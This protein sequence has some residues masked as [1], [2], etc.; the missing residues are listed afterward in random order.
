MIA[1]A[2]RENIGAPYRGRQEAKERGKGKGNRQ[3]DREQ[4]EWGR[5]AKRHATRSDQ[6]G[7]WRDARE[8]EQKKRGRREER[9]KIRRNGSWRK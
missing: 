5:D 9:Q 8:I 6:L 2:N 3:T 1:A 7:E 4:R